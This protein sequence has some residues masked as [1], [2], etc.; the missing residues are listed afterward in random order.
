MKN[1]S[2]KNHYIPCFWSANWNLDYLMKLRNNTINHQ[3]P[4]KV[5]LHTFGVAAK[6][7]YQK[8]AENVFY[9]EYANLSE[10]ESK[11]DL[12]EL[13]KVF[14]NVELD[15]DIEDG[16][17]ENFS[18]FF[19]YEDK[20]TVYE[21]EFKKYLLNLI[22]YKKINNL[23]EKTYISL[24]LYIQILRN[25]YYFSKFTSMINAKKVSKIHLFLEMEKALKDKDFLFNSLFYFI[26]NEWN[27]Y[28]TKDYSLPLSDFPFIESDSSILI[29][30]APDIL[31]EIEMNGRERINNYMIMNE[32]KHKFIYDQIL[33][34]S[35]FN[36][37]CSEIKF[38]KFL[39]IS[40]L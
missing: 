16:F 13:N 24:F 17:N 39:N 5:L 34:N 27:I 29:C 1:I 20:F 8:K 18:Y 35:H 32:S 4:R 6:K 40:N 22:K 33:K 10:V 14:N 36:L 26:N 19:N 31:L 37:V 23:E 11:E 21:N 30:I 9:I 25:P 38:F 12:I 7:I 3:S 28:I 15:F 2:K